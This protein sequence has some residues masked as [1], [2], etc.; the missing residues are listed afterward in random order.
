MDT[1]FAGELEDAEYLVASIPIT[2]T[3]S[4]GYREAFELAQKKS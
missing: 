3:F 2:G 1:K 4:Q